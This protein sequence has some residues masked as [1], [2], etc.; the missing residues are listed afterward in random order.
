[1]V[2]HQIFEFKLKYPHQFCEVLNF[3]SQFRNGF[4]KRQD[5]STFLVGWTLKSGIGWRCIQEVVATWGILSPC[6]TKTTA[7]AWFTSTCC[8]PF[9]GV[10]WVFPFFLRTHPDSKTTFLAWH[11]IAG[12]HQSCSIMLNWPGPRG[13]WWRY[14]FRNQAQDMGFLLTQ[15]F[16]KWHLSSTDILPAPLFLEGARDSEKQIGREL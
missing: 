10:P 5:W 9:R 2:S 11:V 15:I 8:T 14:G 7:L 1:M 12:N 6:V 3:G 4:F 16:S 13:F